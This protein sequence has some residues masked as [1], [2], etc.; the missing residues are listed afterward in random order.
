MQ[1]IVIPEIGIEIEGNLPTDAE[2]FQEL[3][4]TA[5][6]FAVAKIEESL[7]AQ[8]SGAIKYTF[9]GVKIVPRFLELYDHVSRLGEVEESMLAELREAE[10]SQSETVH[11]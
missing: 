2:R 5:S 6:R 8:F 9:E 7:A 11:C 1:I 3:F 4:E 10:E